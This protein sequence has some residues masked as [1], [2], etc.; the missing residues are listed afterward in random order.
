MSAQTWAGPSTPASSASAVSPA[1]HACAMVVSPAAR[2]AVTSA[3]AMSR[4]RAGIG[5]PV[6]DPS[7]ITIFR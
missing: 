3:V 5:V 4:P 2:A 7:S 1:V 6:I